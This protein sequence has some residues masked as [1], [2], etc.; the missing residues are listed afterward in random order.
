M[1]EIYAEQHF[2]SVYNV[3]FLHAWNKKTRYLV[4]TYLE[5][6]V[7]IAY[8]ETHLIVDQTILKTISIEIDFSFIQVFSYV[9]IDPT[10][11]L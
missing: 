9:F 8:V 4:F 5:Y 1:S 10:L 3:I 2:F 11:N 7:H 6:H